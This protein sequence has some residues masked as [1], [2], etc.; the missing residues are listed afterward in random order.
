MGHEFD[1]PVLV[2]QA[3][4]P[5]WSKALGWLS[6]VA[7]AVLLFELTSDPALG[8]AMGCVKFGIGDIRVA[9]WLRRADPNRGRG[10]TCSWFYMTRAIVHIGCMAWI[11]IM[12]MIMLFLVSGPGIPPVQIERQL[13]SALFVILTC[14]ASAALASWMALASALCRGVRVWMD[15]TVKAAHEADVWPPYVPTV[16]RR[17]SIGPGV[18]VAYG[19]FSAWFA[20]MVVMYAGGATIAVLVGLVELFGVGA[21]L[22]LLGLCISILGLI[23]AFLLAPAIERRVAASTPWDCYVES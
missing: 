19:M 13:R 1:D 5:R 22:I 17:A 10:R 21:V 6:M 9:H 20:L 7:L 18:V 12:M 16:C 15:A 2:D 14:F 8:V 4:W 23:T 3:G 11:I